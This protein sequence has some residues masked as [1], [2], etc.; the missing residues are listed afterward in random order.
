MRFSPL[1]RLIL[2][3]SKSTRNL[4]LRVFFFESS[5]NNVFFSQWTFIR[6]A[7]MKEMMEHVSGKKAK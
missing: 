3:E 4:T 1:I 7:R 2:E 5:L 6:Q